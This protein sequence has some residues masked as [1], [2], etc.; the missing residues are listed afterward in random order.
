MD[1]Y[2]GGA[3]IGISFKKTANGFFEV[4]P[5]SLRSK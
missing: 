3:G 4:D 1:N 2:T 5:N